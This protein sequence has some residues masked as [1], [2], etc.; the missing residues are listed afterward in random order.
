M[1][2]ADSS[3]EQSA[4]RAPPRPTGN[5]KTSKT[6]RRRFFVDDMPDKGLFVIIAMAG[7]GS[8]IAA[9]LSGYNAYY[10]AIGAVGLML[11]YGVV[12]YRIPSVRLRVDRL[13]DNFYYLGFIYTLAS[14][15]AALLQLQGEER[16]FD[17]LLGGFGIALLTTI[18]GIAGRV[19][20]VQMRSEIDQIEAEVRR[21]LLSTSEELRSQLALTLREFEIL[22]T[23]VQQVSA[24]LLT[25]SSALAKDQIRNVVASAEEVANGIRDAFASN[26]A[27]AKAAHEA[28]IA[29]T[30]AIR[31]V[32]GGTAGTI[33]QLI[34]RI[35][36]ME[37]PSERLQEQLAELSA[38]IE[39]MLRQV[40]QAA[41][42]RRRRRWRWFAFGRRSEFES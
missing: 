22:R 17:T 4:A 31:D 13:G 26:V 23:G 32:I 16:E 40:R 41:Q 7:F 42:V 12:A 2:Q 38:E 14:L 10:I 27:H 11:L 36:S 3:V 20:F 6:L 15:S 28:N 39:A 8:I 24:E 9:K 18:V 37:L 29:H 30:N 19:M 35:A 21:D 33:D 34:K 5:R 1:A 25:G